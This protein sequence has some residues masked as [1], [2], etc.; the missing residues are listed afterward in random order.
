[1]KRESPSRWL[2][3]LLTALVGLLGGLGSVLLGLFLP[4]VSSLYMMRL[5]FN[6]IGLLAFGFSLLLLVVGWRG[7]KDL[8]SPPFSMPGGWIILLLLWG[9]LVG[10]IL[11]VPGLRGAPLLLAAFHLVLIVLPALFFFVVVT[12]L[13]G[14]TTRLNLRETMTATLGGILSVIPAFILEAIAFL[15][16]LVLVL[17]LALIIPG[18]EAEVERLLQSLQRLSQMDPM[19]IPETAVLNLIRSPVVLSLLTL[20]L[21]LATPLIEEPSKTA[22]VVLFGAR[23]RFDPPR[24]FLWGAAAGLGFSVVEGSLNGLM[25]V[26]GPAAGWASGVGMRAVATAM[27]AFTSGLTGLGWAYVWQRRRRWMLP[28]L[29]LTAI[30]F[31]GLWNLST[32]GMVVASAQM[33]SGPLNLFNTLV[34][35]LSGSL[36][37]VLA[38]TALAGLVVLPLWYRQ[39]WDR[40]R[41]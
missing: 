7:W 3:V 20:V 6:I 16:C 40:S 4:D 25:S 28:V 29:Y 35:L 10:L 39:R 32:I 2:L 1:M 26:E 11:V 38:L 23:R 37:F 5:S 9:G 22:L 15:L 41:A 14:E 21:G 24:A 17:V 13:S 8:P 34:T 19:G 27:H 31:H 12:Q 36:L 18:G 33:L 30:A